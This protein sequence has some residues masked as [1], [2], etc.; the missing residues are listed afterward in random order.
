MLFNSIEFLLFLPAVFFIYWV[1]FTKSVNYRNWFILITSY[2]F[3]GMWDWRFL[4]LIF[5]SSIIDYTIGLK[6]DKETVPIKR[7]RYLWISIVVNIGLLGFFKYFNFFVDSFID[8][9]SFIGITISKPTLN[10]ILPVGISFYTFQTLSYSLDIYKGKLKA[11]NEPIRFL[12]FVSFFPQLVAG[13][14]ERAKDLLPQF[15]DIKKPN[16]LA[17]RSGLFL[18]LWGLFKKIVIADRLAIFVDSVFLESAGG[19]GFSNTIALIFFA[20]QLYIDFSAYSDIAIGVARSLGFNLSLNFNSPYLSNS[21]SSF[22]SR[23]H[24]SLSSWFRDYVYFPLGGNQK[25]KSKTIRNVII[26]FAL[27]G[28]WHGASW[29]FVIWGLLNAV[30]LI[31]LDP[32]LK[33]LNSSKI[34]SFLSPVIVF[35]CWTL[36]LAFFRADGFTNAIQFLSELG[37]SNQEIAMNFGLNESELNL[38][39]LLISFLIVVEI[40]LSKVKTVQQ[41]FESTSFIIRWIVYLFLILAILFYGSYGQTINDQ[42]FIYFQF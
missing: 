39:Y 26:V 5:L 18:V 17:I 20:F 16:Y 38:S 10:I 24:I 30:F 41:W 11:V 8:S 14:I 29:N 22:W 7:K 31:A 4:L 42:S 15:S 25:G 6:I 19:D 27:S 34:L 3:Y 21:F 23:W 1:F 2:F 37:F 32:I 35:S 28:L 12:A 33:H 13:P 9:F 36:S 40:I